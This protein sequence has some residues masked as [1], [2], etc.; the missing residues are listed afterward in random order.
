MIL[1]R[2][3]QAGPAFGD[4]AV[5]TPLLIFA[6]T[7]LLGILSST[8]D[9]QVLRRHDPFQRGGQPEYQPGFGQRVPG[10]GYQGLPQRGR[11]P[12]QYDW[13][14]WAQPEY[15]YAYGQPYYDEGAYPYAYNYG[16]D[17]DYGPNYWEDYGWRGNWDP[18]NDYSYQGYDNGYGDYDY[19]Y[20][21]D[22]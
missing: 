18:W 20:G 11:F 14:I 19:G 6:G 7:L 15:P 8:A 12:Q 1:R 22:E 16:Y 9:A 4:T 2:A 5:K 3:V 21:Y 10:G 13:S 17:E